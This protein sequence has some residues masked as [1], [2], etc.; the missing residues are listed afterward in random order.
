[1]VTELM[2]IKYWSFPDPHITIMI[3][4]AAA[5]DTVARH[6]R[7][8]TCHMHL[9]PFRRLVILLI[10]LLSFLLFLFVLPDFKVVSENLLS[11]L[12]RFLDLV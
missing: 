7:L 4:A 6:G 12:K 8:L 2:P 9:S 11:V 1:M 10:L 3:D 5:T